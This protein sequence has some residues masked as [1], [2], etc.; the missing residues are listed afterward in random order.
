MSVHVQQGERGAEVW[1]GIPGQPQ[2][3]AVLADSV[4]PALRRE[5]AAAG[6]PLQRV[7][8]NGALLYAADAEIETS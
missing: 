1:L 2:E 8:C 6:V 5:L 7:V 3:A 4:L